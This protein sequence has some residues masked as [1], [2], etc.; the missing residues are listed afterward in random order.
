MKN[1]QKDIFV[2][3]KKMMVLLFIFIL[4]L[5]TLSAAGINFDL[6]TSL[7]SIPTGFSWLF[8]NFIPTETSLAYLP[9]ILSKLLQTAL[10]SI[11]ATTTAAI[12]ALFMAIFGSRETGI[13]PVVKGLAHILASFFRNMPIVVWAMILLISFKQSEFTGYLAIFF[14]TF[15]Y[16][17]R[18]FM[19]TIDEVA[20]STIEALTATGASYFQIV[21][22]GVLPMVGSQLI[23]W[24]LFLI[25][26]NIRDATLVGILTGTGIGF[27]FDLYY[28]KFEYDITG[29]II[30]SIIIVVIGLE[31]FSNR[32]RRAII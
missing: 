18:S 23:S 2:Q 5:Y 11:T 3:R 21:F 15:G 8:T 24:V 28:K 12:F 25:E 4:L 6:F 14:A 10:M 20:G 19:E 1:A 16:L 26:N 29:M 31:L 9:M 22:Q 17:T 30:L 27:L 7:P 13:H 32:I